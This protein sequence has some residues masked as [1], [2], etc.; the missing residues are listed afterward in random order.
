MAQSNVCHNTSR[1]EWHV[2]FET[3]TVSL[4]SITSS[5]V[6]SQTCK[7]NFAWLRAAPSSSANRTTRYRFQQKGKRFSC[8]PMPPAR[9]YIATRWLRRVATPPGQ[10]LTSF[11]KRGSDSLVHQG[12]QRVD[13]SRRI[14]F[15]HGGSTGDR[16][17]PEVS[18]NAP[19]T[20]NLFG[21]FE[22]NK[23]CLRVTHQWIRL[24]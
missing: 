6:L 1:R 13:A 11:G 19:G 21:R 16:C 8:P 17:L 9:R 22:I 23:N 14:G 12:L 15:L 20:L 5:L 18:S 10:H 7:F 2:K 4:F 24:N 3:T